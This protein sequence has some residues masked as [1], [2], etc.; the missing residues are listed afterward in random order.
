MVDSPTKYKEAFCVRLGAL[1]RAAGYTQVEM[2]NMLGIPRD[3]YAKYEKRSLLRHDLIS[4]VAEITGHDVW[5][6]LTGK[7]HQN[8]APNGSRSLSEPELYPGGK[9]RAKSIEKGNSEG[10]EG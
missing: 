6:V 8:D 10:E 1:R 9:R 4:H 7:P 5:F 2:A 3:T